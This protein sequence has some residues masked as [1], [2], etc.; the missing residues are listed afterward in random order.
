MRSVFTMGLLLLGISILAGRPACSTEP[1]P[2]IAEDSTR[3]IRRSPDGHQFVAWFDHDA[4][5]PIGIARC[6]ILRDEFDSDATLFSF[7]GPSRF[8]N[9]AWSPSSTRC[10][11]T[12][13]VDWERTLVWVIY[14]DRADKWLSRKLDVLAPVEA[15]YRQ[16]IGDK[17]SP[18]F[19]AHLDKIE[20]LSGTRVRF[21]VWSNLNDPK[22]ASSG[23][24]WVMIDTQSPDAKPE[25]IK[26]SNE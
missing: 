7:V 13:E 12:N 21:L 4:G 17:D 20:W 10:V 8:T 22:L 6:I 16:A 24:Y 1:N 15:A 18:G 26:I 5:A 19:R 9:A 11:I 2:N 23:R 14:K 3:E 25:M